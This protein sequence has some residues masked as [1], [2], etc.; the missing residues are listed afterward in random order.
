MPCVISH[1]LYVSFV[2][3]YAERLKAVESHWSERVESM[4]VRF[5]C[6]DDVFR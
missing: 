2:K 4:L 6:I 1:S 5:M 3:V